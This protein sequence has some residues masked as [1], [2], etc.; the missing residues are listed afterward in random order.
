M[1]G[2]PWLGLNLCVGGAGRVGAAPSGS[3]GAAAIYWRQR[4]R[5]SCLR[6]LGTGSGGDSGT[7]DR[8]RTGC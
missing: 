2:S 7:G 6:G 3:D 1:A 4:T 5:G 8:L